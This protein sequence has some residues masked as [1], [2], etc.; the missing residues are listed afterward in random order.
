MGLMGRCTSTV[1]GDELPKTSNRNQ[2]ICRI[3]LE[4]GAQNGNPGLQTRG[5]QS[6]K[7]KVF[8]TA[9]LLSSAGVVAFAVADEDTSQGTAIKKPFDAAAHGKSAKSSIPVMTYHGGTVMNQSNTV[10]VIYYGTFPAT[11]QPIINDFLAGLTGS[12][13]YGVDTEYN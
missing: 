3:L 7:F 8:L 13:P 10:Y 4:A 9:A 12:A 6:M 2:G 1:P 11:T 5:S